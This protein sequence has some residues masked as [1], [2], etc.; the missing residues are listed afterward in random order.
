LQGILPDSGPVTVTT[1]CVGFDQKVISLWIASA[2]DLMPPLPNGGDGKLRRCGRGA[3]I[4]PTL[5]RLRIINTVRN[6]FALGITGKVVNIDLIRLLTIA[7]ARIP[8]RTDQLCF[9]GIDTDNGLAPPDKQGFSPLNK[10]VLPVTVRMR[11][12][13]QAFDVRFE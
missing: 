4:H 5:I 7:G 13:D 2:A 6:G 10:T 1:P 12:S 3:H 11:F 8:E 9:L